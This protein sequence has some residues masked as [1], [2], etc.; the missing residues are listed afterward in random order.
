M[1][2]RRLSI[3]PQ[4]NSIEDGL[5][6]LQRNFTQLSENLDEMSGI[7]QS[8]QQFNLNFANFLQGLQLNSE[9]LCFPE[10]PNQDTY[11][12]LNRPPTPPTPTPEPVVVKERAPSSPSKK[13][14]VGFIDK[15]KKVVR[16]RKPVFQTN[17]IVD[18]LPGRFKDQP[19]RS[20]IENILKELNFNRDGMYMH[21]IVRDV[22][23]GLSR[24]K[25]ADYMNALVHTEA[26][27]RTNRKG[28]LFYLNP[29]QFPQ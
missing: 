21:E 26:V 22:G 28:H 7:N 14:H 5:F 11:Q 10:A 9:C 8:L 16:K 29:D 17:R 24:S 1:S 18:Q 3:Y 20:T 13:K 12:L 2:A 27:V 23:S 4:S 6:E 25:C 15:P 19:H